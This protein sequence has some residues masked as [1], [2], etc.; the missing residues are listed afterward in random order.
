MSHLFVL[1]PIVARRKSMT[2]FQTKVQS[3]ENTPFAANIPP[4]NHPRVQPYRR[5]AKKNNTT[6]V[7]GTTRNIQA[8]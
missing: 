1:A 5:E 2:G 8:T 3:N 4:Y 6:N 7:T